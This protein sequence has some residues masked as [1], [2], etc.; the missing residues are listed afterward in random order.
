MA[1]TQTLKRIGGSVGTILPKSMLERFHLGAGDRVFVV[2]TEEGL[3][4]TPFDPDFAEALEA[5]ERGA[6]KYRN[7]L[8]ELAK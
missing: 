7:A 5:Y 2:E 1:K 4:I 6:K 8:R 3:L